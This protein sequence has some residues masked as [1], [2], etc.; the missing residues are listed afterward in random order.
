MILDKHSGRMALVRQ[1]ELAECGLAC[2]A[3]VAGFHGLDIDLIN[4]RRAHAPSQRG[5]T[6]RNLMAIADSLGL[7]PRPVKLPLEALDRLHVPAILHWDMDHFVVLERCERGRAL[8]H[9]PEGWTR[10]MPLAEVSNHFT[11]VALELRPSASFQKGERRERLHLSQLWDSLRGLLPVGAQIFALSLLLAIAAL[12]APYYLQLALDQAY[13]A[14][15]IDLLTVLALG[16]G[17]VVILSMLTELLRAHLLLAA[18][19][20]IGL[21]LASNL[22]RRLFRLPVDWFGRRHVGDVLTR[23]QSV[24]PVQSFLTQG[25]IAGLLDGLIAVATLGLML[26]YSPALAMV[27]VV[28][29]LLYALVRLMSFTAERAA[30]EAAIVAGGKEQSA[31]IESLRGMTTIRMFGRELHRHM[32]WQNRLVDSVNADIRVA[33]IGIWQ[34][35]ANTV[36]FGVSNILLIWLA[37]RLSMAG[38]FSVGMVIA[39]LAYK[40]QFVGKTAA[41]INQAIA[42]RMLN[43]H[44]ERMG[45]I[46]LT[47]EDIAFDGE[48]RHRRL[49]GRL[50]LRNVRYRYAPS[51]PWVLEDVSLSI[52]AGEH[53]AITGPSGAGKS[54]LAAILLGLVQPTEGEVLIDGEPIRQFGLRAY[55]RQIGAVL[56][57]DALFAG[58]LI[59]NIA[60]ADDQ[61]DPE[62]ALVAASAAAIHAEIL[63]M[64]MQYNTLVG[65]MGS[66]L[67]GGQRQRIL[68]ARA[69]YRLPSPSYSPAG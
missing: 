8:I 40:E 69:L 63:A 15:D 32:L 13:P 30:Q 28:A 16:F 42:F 39:F 61:A 38:G 53:V 14:L 64:P 66:A 47:P 49:E 50:E 37:I 19:S 45:E 29:T 7:S 43:L 2:V 35:A 55:R 22:A 68:L 65:D 10:W 27:T 5:Q 46:A 48:D 54:T 44:L 57:D 41:F 20:S 26:W 24:T 11:G 3:M 58:S 12:A 4:L 1:A 33:R 18:G 62:R 52:A 25:A 31:L 9:N 21:G 36:I 51:D 60:F 59:D 17:A 23:F 67:S 34:S 56:Q 6:L